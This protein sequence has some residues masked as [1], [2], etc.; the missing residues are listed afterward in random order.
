MCVSV[1]LRSVRV[2]ININDAEDQQCRDE[3]ERD[4]IKREKWKPWAALAKLLASFFIY[5]CRGIKIAAHSGIFIKNFILAASFHVIN[6][7]SHRADWLAQH[8]WEGLCALAEKMWCVYKILL[9]EQVCR[10]S[11]ERTSFLFR[12]AA[13]RERALIK[14]C[15]CTAANNSITANRTNGFVHTARAIK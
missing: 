2:S 12:C 4:D 13:R 15:Q 1:C 7:K 14:H 3:K 8:P 10:A 9:G 11:S 5:M 6:I